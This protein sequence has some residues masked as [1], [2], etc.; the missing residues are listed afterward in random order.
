MVVKAEWI[1]EAADKHVRINIWGAVIR[2][3][4]DLNWQRFD[5]ELWLVN[6][7][8]EGV[9]DFSNAV[10]GRNA[11]F[12]GAFEQ[13]AVFTGAK[14]E[15]EAHFE[16]VTFGSASFEGITVGGVFSANGAKFTGMAWFDRSTFDGEATFFGA[17]FQKQAV[18]DG[19]EF[20][21]KAAFESSFG[22]YASFQ[23]VHFWGE[24]SF[25]GIPWTNKANSW[26][27][28]RA[29]FQFAQFESP[30]DLRGVAFDGEANFYGIKAAAPL[31]FGGASFKGQ[32]IF[33]KADL[34]SDMN[35]SGATFYGEAD[36][37]RVHIMGS[38]YFNNWAS[39]GPCVFH[40]VAK[41]YSDEVEGELRFDGGTVF[42]K[43]ATFSEGKFR[44]GAVFADS[45]FLGDAAFTGAEFSGPSM[46]GGANFRGTAD[47][48]FA[49]FAGV[50]LFGSMETKQLSFGKEADFGGALFDRAAFFENAVFSHEAKFVATKFQ[51]EA[52]IAAVVF[53]QASDFSRAQFQG[54]AFFGLTSDESAAR[55][56]ADVEFA[57]VKFDYARSENDVHFEAASFGG[58]LSMRGTQFRTVYFA[59]NGR[60]GDKEQLSDYIDLRDCTYD[61]I[62]AN[63]TSLLRFANGRRRQQ[64]YD[65]QPYLQLEKALRDGGLDDQAN[66]VYIEGKTNEIQIEP[67]S[68]RWRDRTYGFILNYGVGYRPWFVSG[69]LILIGTFVFWISGSAKPVHHPTGSR[70]PQVLFGAAEL[71]FRAFLPFDL[72]ERSR[73]EISK[74]VPAASVTYNL[75][76]LSGWVLVPILVLN[77]TGIIHR[78]P[79]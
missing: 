17:D 65:P 55:K 57:D 40:G 43:S 29:Y 4:L 49:Q 26:F 39:S 76:R 41:F 56:E 28:D 70:K 69:G 2:G 77:V 37:A 73:W 36:F 13:G 10:F 63:W 24:A 15:K 34:S 60:V 21:R 75:L 45:T 18:F 25:G 35:F 79:K 30:A 12:G 72:P 7:T 11:H 38:A 19:S 5:E 46:F 27:R 23:H 68:S 22:K 50:S 8:F 52:R 44:G 64:P 14:F 1:R 53:Q 20:H 51:S 59:R 3:N 48:R 54:P 71:S 47:F 66:A 67:W 78:V 74:D 61:R 42:M 58:P 33:E 16:N 62:Q 9:A 6:C 31:Y 32:L